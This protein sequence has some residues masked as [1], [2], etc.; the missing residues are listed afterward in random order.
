MSAAVATVACFNECVNAR[1]LPRLV[2]LMTE[3]HTFVDLDL[4]TVAGRDACQL[5]WRGFFTSFPDYRNVF[6]TMTADP[7]DE[8]VTIVGRS[9]CSIP[10]LDGPALWQAH[11]RDGLVARWQVYHD[12]PEIRETLGI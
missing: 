6:A 7:A 4:T 3:D 10:L 12:T 9:R 1:D 11:I 8:V 5:V 2:A